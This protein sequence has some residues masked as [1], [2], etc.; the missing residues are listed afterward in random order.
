MKHY[1]KKG[2]TVLDPIF[3]NLNEI[4]KQDADKITPDT[5]GQVREDE[6]V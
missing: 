2:K 1:A 6:G 5:Q 4:N 3:D